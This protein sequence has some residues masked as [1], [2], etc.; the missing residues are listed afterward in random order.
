MGSYRLGSRHNRGFTLIELLVVIAIIAI[1]AAILFPVFAKMKDRAKMSNCMQNQRQIFFGITQYG[2][3]NN[4]WWPPAG[5]YI[6]NCGYTVAW[7]T[8][9]IMPYIK[10]KDIF[11]CPNT[12]DWVRKYPVPGGTGFLGSSYFYNND[13]RD[14]SRR[15]K[16]SDVVL[17]GDQWADQAHVREKAPRSVPGNLCL[18]ITVWTMCDGHF[19]SNKQ[20]TPW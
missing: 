11:F 4:D 15:A 14:P 8:D 9:V 2:D 17:M 13:A 19:V 18:E 6:D 12:R 1:L 20:L 5:C 3:D 7:Q 10:N 16:P